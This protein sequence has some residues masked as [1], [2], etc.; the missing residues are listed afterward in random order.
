VCGGWFSG[1]AMLLAAGAKRVCCRLYFSYNES[2]VK[3]KVKSCVRLLQFFVYII[4][5]PCRYAILQ[6]DT[7]CALTRLFAR[8]S[9]RCRDKC[10]YRCVR[11]AIR[12]V[13]WASLNSR[14]LKSASLSVKESFLYAF[15]F[16]AAT[17]ITFPQK[18]RSSKT[19]WCRFSKAIC[20]NLIKVNSRRRIER[21]YKG[22]VSK[23]RRPIR[24]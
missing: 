3:V 13:A 4:L 21:D 5:R 11:R 17:V 7:W 6:L 2:G 20:N 15:D 12:W 22:A 18:T 9:G 23:M 24:L 16:P 8:A 19:I 14:R 1:P 10:L